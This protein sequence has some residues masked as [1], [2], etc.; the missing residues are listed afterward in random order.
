MNA[1]SLTRSRRVAV[2]LLVFIAFAFMVA[3]NALANILPL[4]GVNT[5]AL[6]DEIPNL[7]VPAGLTFSVWGLIYLLLAFLVTFVLIQAFSS[8]PFAG[9]WE[10]ADGLLFA[11]NALANGAWIFAWHWRIIPLSLVLMLVILGT[12]VALAE[13]IHRRYSPGGAFHGSASPRPPT[14]LRLALSTPIH[15]YL[16]WICVAT[17]ANVTALL[18]TIGWDGW[19]IDQRIW[20]V[21]VIGA[22]LAV[23]LGLVF[24]RRA[25][26]APLVVVWAYVG[27]IIKRFTADGWTDSAVWISAAA[28]SLAILVALGVRLLRNGDREAKRAEA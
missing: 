28:A 4:N 14:L 24:L 13:R 7:F 19:G 26:A 8:R 23:A 11:A 9:A 16:G 5:G 10:P 27:I 22:G 1:K 20:T 25:V 21:L 6:S 12:L 2:A 3:V 18:V 17:I 15:V